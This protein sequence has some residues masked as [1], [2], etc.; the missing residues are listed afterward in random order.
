M[1]GPKISTYELRI[2]EQ[3]RKRQEQIREINLRLNKIKLKLQ[4][5]QREYNDLA[6]DVIRD[7]MRQISY[8][9]VKGDLRVAF[10]NLRKLENRIKEEEQLLKEEKEFQEKIKLEKK[11]KELKAKELL[12]NLEEI[13]NEYKEI[14]NENIKNQLQ[15]FKK[16]IKLNPDNENLLNQIEN[17]ENRL[18]NMYAEYLEQE[19][20]KRYVAKTFSEILGGGVN[21]GDGGLVVSGNLDGVPIKVRIEDNNL[22]FD[23]P[24]NGSCVR[25]MEK[26]VKEL[27]NKEVYLGPIKALKTGKVLNQTTQRNRQRIRQ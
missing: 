8:I 20:N 3:E 12:K 15:T 1:S 24:E 6:R 18:S 25:T 13:E 10:R 7:L 21:E 26:I 2:R 22:H 5:F 17:F 14:L 23:T 19:E 27:E 11:R 9:S 4:D 16:A